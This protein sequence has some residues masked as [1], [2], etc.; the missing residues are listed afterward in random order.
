MTDPYT[1]A[2]LSD[3]HGNAAALDAV[4]ADLAGVPHDAT[5]V[6]GDLALL[7]PRPAEALARLRAL[8]AP[9]VYGNTDRELLRQD[10]GRQ[11]PLVDW[12]RE[13]IGEDG[14]AYLASLPFDLRITPPGGASPDDDLLV[15]HATPTD[16]EAVLIL[17]PGPSGTWQVTPEAE[18]TALV[19]DVRAS[20]IVLGHIHVASAGSVRGRRLA[21]VGAVGFPFDGDPRAAYALVAWNG[22]AWRLTHRRVAYDHAAVAVDVRALDPPHADAI[23]RRLIE[24]RSVPLV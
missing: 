21:T 1:V 13:R 9:T 24:A 22:R 2:V 3:V 5:V 8:D 12:T 11:D 18:A 7:G 16:V 23:A 19:G 15:V 10:P 6:A 4:L 14:L 20:L 17:E